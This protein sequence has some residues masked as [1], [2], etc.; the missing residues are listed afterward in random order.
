MMGPAS[1][2][3]ETGSVHDKLLSLFEK[4]GYEVIYPEVQLV[5]HSLSQNKNGVLS[6]IYLTYRAQLTECGNRLGV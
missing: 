3:S 2:D 5:P 4:A 1:G 6:K